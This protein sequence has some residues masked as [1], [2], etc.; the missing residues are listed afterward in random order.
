MQLTIRIADEYAEKIA[1][2]ADQMGLKKVDVTRLA[3]RRVID[4]NF[5]DSPNKPYDRVKHLV[6]CAESGLNDLGRHH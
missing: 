3:L 4:E 1:R 6:G 2:L 5:N